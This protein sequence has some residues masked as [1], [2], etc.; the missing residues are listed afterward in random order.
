MRS[1]NSKLVLSGINT[2]EY[3][4]GSFCSTDTLLSNIVSLNSF[5]LFKY[6]NTLLT[7]KMI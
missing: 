1:V 4:K 3:S 2:D 7:T 6:S 5:F